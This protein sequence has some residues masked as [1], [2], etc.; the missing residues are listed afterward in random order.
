MRMR[1]MGTRQE[2]DAALPVMAEVFDIHEV[3]D[4]YP[5]RGTSQLGRVYVDVG[6][7]RPVTIRATA[8]RT[9][10]KTINPGDRRRIT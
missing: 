2:I 1:L 6:G 8:A 9:D 4:F 5:N 3:S 10:R 7:V